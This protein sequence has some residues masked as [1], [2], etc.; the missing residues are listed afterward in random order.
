MDIET[1]TEMNELSKDE[2]DQINGG[3]GLGSQFLVLLAAG[4]GGTTDGDS[5]LNHMLNSGAHY[6]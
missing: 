2:L 3:N 5:L 1:K 4:I 6:K